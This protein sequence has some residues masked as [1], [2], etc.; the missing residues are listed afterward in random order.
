MGAPVKTTDDIEAAKFGHLQIEEDEVGT[1]LL[2]DGESG[3]TVLR[4]A[5]HDDVG[6]LFEFLAQ[7]AASDWLIVDD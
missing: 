7:D 3:E 5:G 1:Q 6:E 2:D 4:F